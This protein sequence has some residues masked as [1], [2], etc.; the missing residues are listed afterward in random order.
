MESDQTQPGSDFS[1]LLDLCARQNKI[2][3]SHG[4]PVGNIVLCG[5]IAA[6]SSNIVI[7]FVYH[8]YRH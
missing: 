7:L 6:Q 1:W 2:R 3:F 8:P 5:I 4:G